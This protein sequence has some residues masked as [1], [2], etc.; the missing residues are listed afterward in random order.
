LACVPTLTVGPFGQSVISQCDGTS[1]ISTDG[2]STWR[3]LPNGQY[4]FSRTSDATVFRYRSVF[5]A[6]VER[7]DDGG[8]TFTGAAMRGFVEQLGSRFEADANDPATLYFLTYGNTGFHYQFSRNGGDDWTP[9]ATW[10]AREIFA[11]AGITGTLYTRAPT[12]PLLRSQ[13]FG[14]TWEPLSA[15]PSVTTTCAKIPA[16]QVGATLAGVTLVFPELALLALFDGATGEDGGTAAVP[17]AT[18]ASILASI[19][20]A[21]MAAAALRRRRRG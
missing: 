1:E 12:G 9:V 14:A 8:L 7:S 21:G 3:P 6:A 11:V 5:G 13:D 20:L 17:L 15:L 4:A 19:L 2:G 16:V 18:A 10:P